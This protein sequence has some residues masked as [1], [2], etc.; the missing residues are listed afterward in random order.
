MP[1]GLDDTRVSEAGRRPGAAPARLRPALAIALAALAAA[2]LAAPGGAA[3]QPR[4]VI[5]FRGHTYRV[6]ASWPVYRLARHPTMCARLDRRAVY[7]GTPGSGQSCPAHAAGRRRAILIGARPQPRAS[8][9]TAAGPVAR[10]SAFKGVGFDAC[11]A[12]SGRAMSAWRSSTAYRAVGVYI[13]GTNRACSQPNLTSG[14][15]TKQTGSGWHLIPTY[16]G[17][18]AP[19]S[20]CSSCAKFGVKNPGSKGVKAANDAVPRAQAV[21]IGY[22]SPI[23]FDLEAYTRTSSASKA[24]RAFLASWTKRLHAL[25]YVS[26]VYSSGASG[27]REL[28]DAVGTGFLEPDEIWIAN[29]NGKKTANDPYVPA[30]LWS[31]HR[32]RQYRGGHNE[33]HGGV[34][35]NID[36]D[37]IAGATAGGSAPSPDDPVGGFEAAFSPGP[38]RVVVSGWAFDPDSPTDPVA[39]RAYVG[40]TASQRGARG[41]GLGAAALPRPDV[42]SAHPEAGDDHGFDAGLLTTRSGK[43]PVCVYAVNLGAGSDRLLGCRKVKIGAPLTIGRIS[44][45]ARALGLTVRCRWPAG[46]RCRGRIVVHARMK[47]SLARGAKPVGIYLAHRGFKLGGG[48][49]HRFR[50]PLNKRARAV[51]RLRRFKARLKVSIPGLQLHRSVRVGRP[52]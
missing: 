6:P 26:G 5:H 40:G 8:A 35:I 14:W 4:K 33:T 23:Y 21:G 13:G 39:I 19:T 48:V 24:V 43:Q 11:A 51:L 18:Q 28:V 7:L 49:S 10:A 2:L 32:L 1:Q 46:T 17:L 16:V 52:K 3:A 15:V 22:G 31:G 20:S 29:W 50:L 38:G 45:G 27:I 34:T 42:G 47:L 9:A 44:S 41:Y 30:G 12:P 36:N 25:G 37:Y